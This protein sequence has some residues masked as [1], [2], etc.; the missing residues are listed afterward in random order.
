MF[1]KVL[2]GVLWKTDENSTKW[3]NENLLIAF[4]KWILVQN[5]GL[6]IG[7]LLKN[8]IDLNVKPPSD[9]CLNLITD[10]YFKEFHSNDDKNNNNS[11]FV[12]LVS[13]GE[14]FLLWNYNPVLCRKQFWYEWFTTVN[15]SNQLMIKDLLFRAN[16]F[17]TCFMIMAKFGCYKEFEIVHKSWTDF[18]KNFSSY[19]PLDKTRAMLNELNSNPEALERYFPIEV[20]KLLQSRIQ[21][22]D[23]T[24]VIIQPHLNKFKIKNSSTKGNNNLFSVLRHVNES[25][26]GMILQSL[27]WQKL[28]QIVNRAV[29]DVRCLNSE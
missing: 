26:N 29:E 3:L 10:L 5:S 22:A 17:Y 21:L 12:N 19:L 24:S 13:L 14:T 15:N 16:F 7:Q 2:K 28:I 9:K 6:H 4:E 11:S 20:S 18:F 1:L 27:G 8:L 25:S 23:S